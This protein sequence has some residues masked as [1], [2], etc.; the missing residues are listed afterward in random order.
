MRLVTGISIKKLLIM[1]NKI[2]SFLIVS[3]LIISLITGEFSKMGNVVLET[4]NDS[5]EVII[6]LILSMTFWRGIFEISLQTGI[7]NLIT[8]WFQKLT[9]LIFLKTS[10]QTILRL[11]TSNIFANFLGL[12]HAA[13]PVGLD[14][15]RVINESEEVNKE[16]L[17]ARLVLFN[18]SGI[19]ILPTSIYAFRNK[20]M[21]TTPLYLV[22]IIFI[23]TILSAVI[24]LS[25]ESLTSNL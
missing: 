24:S 25:L 18:C 14:A 3:G 22:L 21:A 9:S 19:S 6:I 7:I 8:K 4:V 12:S 15:I 5:F 10:N 11:I 20:F 2:W 16:R 13:T 23:L 1:L 17:I